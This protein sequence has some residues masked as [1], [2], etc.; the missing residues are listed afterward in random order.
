MVDPSGAVRQTFAQEGYKPPLFQIQD[1]D[2]DGRDELLVSP[3]WGG[4]G[5]N[6]WCV[7]RASGD[8]AHFEQAGEIFSA[9]RIE[10][11]EDRFVKW[12]SKSGA[13]GKALMF[14]RF[15]DGRMKIL[16]EVGWAAPGQEDNKTDSWR[17]LLDASQTDLVAL[18]MD[19]HT[20]QEHFCARELM[21]E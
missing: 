15:V 11:T 2:H 4:T 3:S 10:F 13:G 21:W 9:S 8:S 17:C 14:G 5:G 12:T 18:G 19:E 7:W 1:L 6:T 16:A 20:A